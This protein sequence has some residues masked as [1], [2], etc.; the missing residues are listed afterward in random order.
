MDAPPNAEDVVAENEVKV[1]V[2]KVVVVEGEEK[3]HEY[4]VPTAL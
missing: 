1:V 2:A 3:C 4:N